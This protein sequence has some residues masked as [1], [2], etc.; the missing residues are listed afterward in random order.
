MGAYGTWGLLRG[1]AL[2]VRVLFRDTAMVDAFAGST[3]GVILAAGAQLEEILASL[4]RGCQG[5]VGGGLSRGIGQKQAGEEEK[6]AE[7]ESGRHGIHGVMGWMWEEDRRVERRE[8]RCAILKKGG[9][10]RRVW[11]THSGGCA[12]RQAKLVRQLPTFN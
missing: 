5:G 3:L 4:H 11:G 8:R 2:V 12:S 1:F 10:R 7:K 9:E 6:Q